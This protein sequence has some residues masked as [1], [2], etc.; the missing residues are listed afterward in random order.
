MNENLIFPLVMLLF[1]IF[2]LIIPSVLYAGVRKIA[3]PVPFWLPLLL[4]AGVFLIAGGILGGDLIEMD[5]VFVGTLVIFTFILLLMS[6]AVITPYLWLGEKTEIVRPGLYFTCLSVFAVALFFYSTMGHAYEGEPFSPFGQVLPLSGWIL[7]GFAMIFNLQNIVY[8]PAIP[9]V[10]TL[11]LMV[12]HYLQALI[13][14]T[15]FFGLMSV[16]SVL[17]NE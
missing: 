17:P 5:N 12:G 15:A 8:S 10:H 6:L 3:T 16:Q 11:L 2:I 14:A 9:L 1:L 4:A 7:D 13:I